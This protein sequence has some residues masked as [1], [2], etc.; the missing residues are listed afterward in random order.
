MARFIR[1]ECPKLNFRGIMSMGEV[2]NV[3]EFRLMHEL[4]Q[5]ILPDFDI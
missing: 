1:D 2:G 4:K 5:T 3:A